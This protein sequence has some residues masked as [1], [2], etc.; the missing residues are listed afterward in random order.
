MLYHTIYMCVCVCVRVCRYMYYMH[1]YYIFC[2]KPQNKPI[3]LGAAACG[4]SWVRSWLRLCANGIRLQGAMEKMMKQTIGPQENAKF[5]EETQKMFIK[6]MFFLTKCIQILQNKH[7]QWLER[8]FTRNLIQEW[9][10][11]R[12]QVNQTMYHSAMNPKQYTQ[13]TK[14]KTD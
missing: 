1:V 12:G 4:P 5:L 7:V 6:Y 9:M 8:F 14:P 13:F 10:P 3:S 2:H 11:M